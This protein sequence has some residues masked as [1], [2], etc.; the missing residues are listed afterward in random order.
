MLQLYPV[1]FVY[2]YI[3]ASIVLK[4][5]DSYS[6]PFSLQISAKYCCKTVFKSSAE[7][8]D[9]STVMHFSFFHLSNLLTHVAVDFMV[10]L[11]LFILSRLNISLSVVEANTDVLLQSFALSPDAIPKSSSAFL[12]LLIISLSLKNC[13]ISPE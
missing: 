13:N 1:P 3:A 12:S 5:S 6:S 9:K 10:F 4:L 11:L 7:M 8:Y 2:L